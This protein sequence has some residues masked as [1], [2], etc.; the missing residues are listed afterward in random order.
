MRKQGKIIWNEGIPLKV[1]RA[2]SCFV[3]WPIYNGGRFGVPN[4]SCGIWT[5]VLNETYNQKLLEFERFV[6]QRTIVVT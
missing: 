1:H 2:H 6:V 3:R 5:P 4:E